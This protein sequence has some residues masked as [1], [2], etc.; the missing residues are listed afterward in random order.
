MSRTS[1]GTETRRPHGWPRE[2]P[3]H[4]TTQR[5]RRGR[6]PAATRLLVLGLVLVVV[7]VAVA[8]GLVTA[9]HDGNPPT[10]TSDVPPAA[11]PGLDLTAPPSAPSVL[12]TVTPAPISVARLKRHVAAALA[13]PALGGHLG[14]AVAQLGNPAAGWAEGART[15]M[16]A[17]TLKLLTTTAALATLGGDH[18]F[19][20]SVVRGTRPGTI[21]LV[22]GGDPLLVDTAAQAGAVYPRPASLQALAAATAA[23]LR[24][25]GVRRVSLGYD[26]SLFT[27]PAV[28]PHWPSTYITDDVVSP[29]TALWVNEGRTAPGPGRAQRQARR[30][31]RP[32]V[33]HRAREGRHPGQWRGDGAAARDGGHDDRL[34]AVRRRPC[35][36]SCSTSSSSATTRVPRCC[37]VRSPSPRAGPGPARPE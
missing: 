12:A 21:V 5:V 30:R 6:P 4:G 18:R 33:P 11:G 28:N 25:Q 22:G 36:R 1:P 7:V 26:T 31:G 32:A 15:V 37:F 13:S 24:S 14:F 35:R 19:T 20:T 10:S 34:A 17:S 27:G 23:R 29:I 2:G 8:A 9:L 3:S 16:P